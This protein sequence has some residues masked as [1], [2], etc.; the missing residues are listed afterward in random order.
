MQKNQDLFEITSRILAGLK[1]VIK[2]MIVL[3]N[4]Q[5]L[6]EILYHNLNYSQNHLNL[7]ATLKKEN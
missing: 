5:I 1:E 7:L 4:H 3:K 2:K 6:K